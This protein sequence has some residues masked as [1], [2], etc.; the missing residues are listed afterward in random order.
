MAFAPLLLGLAGTVASGIS[1]HNAQA[2]NS[3]IQGYERGA[4]NSL[5]GNAETQ[6]LRTGREAVDRQI[7]AFGA[8]GVGYGGSAK[9]AIDASLVNSELDAL[10]VRYRGQLTSWGYGEQADIDKQASKTSLENSGVLAGAQLVK[11]FSP[12]AAA[13]FGSA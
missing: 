5:A 2:T 1:Q 8:S 10:N 3:Q 12:Q 7:T 13:I 11:G 6:Q 9:K 4:A